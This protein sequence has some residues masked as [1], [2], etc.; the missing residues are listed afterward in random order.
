MQFV[1]GK[2]RVRIED[3]GVF[4]SVKG[5]QHPTVFVRFT[6][7]GVYNPTTGEVDECP[8]EAG[9]YTKAITDKTID[10]VLSDLKAIGYDGVK[11]EQFDPEAPGAANLFGREIDVVCEPETYEGKTRERWSIYREP[12]R[13]KMGRDALARLDGVY[14]DKIRKVLGDGQPKAAPAPVAPNDDK[15]F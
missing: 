11:L 4:Q 6:L 2:Y 12:Q 3:Y 5:Q 14:A 10:W 13:K 9:E 7:V 1:K 15:P 8:A